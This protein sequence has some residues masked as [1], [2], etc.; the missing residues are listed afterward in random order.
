MIP[1]ILRKAVAIATSVLFP[2]YSGCGRCGRKWP[3]CKCHII[4]YN[5]TSGC[6]PLCEGCWRELSIEDRIPYYN[7]MVDEWEAYSGEDYKYKRKE[8]LN[9]VREGK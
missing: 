1:L 3:V 6:F 4:Q 7:D 9:A 2:G 5:A 8:I